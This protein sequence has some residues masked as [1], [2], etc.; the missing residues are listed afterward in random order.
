MQD[1]FDIPEWGM[2]PLTDVMDYAR[3][4]S[5]GRFATEAAS[6]PG[7]LLAAVTPYNAWVSEDRWSIVSDVFDHV[8]GSKVSGRV[9]VATTAAATVTGYLYAAGDIGGA[10]A[11]SAI[12]SLYGAV[13][14]SCETEEEEELAPCEI[15]FGP[16]QEDYKAG[17]PCAGYSPE[18]Y[19]NYD[20]KL[21]GDGYEHISDDGR[22]F[23]VKMV[24][25]VIKAVCRSSGIT[26]LNLINMADVL[27]SWKMVQGSNTLTFDGKIPVKVL[28]QLVSYQVHL[29][30]PVNRG[31]TT[32][33]NVPQF[34]VKRED[35]YTVITVK[36]GNG[37]TFNIRTNMDIFLDEIVGAVNEPED[38]VLDTLIRKREGLV[39]KCPDKFYSLLQ[40]RTQRHFQSSKLRF[41]EGGPGSGSDFWD[42]M[43]F[44]S[45]AL[46]G[47]VRSG[48]KTEKTS[49]NT[50]TESRNKFFDTEAPEPAVELTPA[51]ERPSAQWQSGFMDNGKDQYNANFNSFFNDDDHNR[52]QV[53]AEG[54]TSS[55]V[56]R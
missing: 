11:S 6:Y 37:N 17:R 33:T 25:G 52:S 16:P 3:S 26:V 21:T 7:H 9:V 42:K 54:D 56:Y 28:A 13:V 53:E 15:Y 43:N 24:D 2:P 22:A 29:F 10:I 48:W 46:S 12:T 41:A 38:I 4:T 8:S 23:Q 36:F 18:F 39:G 32:T 50:P 45:N 5:I 27:N 35:G 49:W 30:D 51:P 1:L 44:N 47:D 14:Y 19:H 55:F 40:H 34:M 20:E 31:E